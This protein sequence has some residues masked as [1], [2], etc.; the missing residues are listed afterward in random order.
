MI[1]EAFFTKLS[2]DSG[3]SAIAST[4]VYPVRLPQNPVFPCVSFQVI[5]E[6][7]IYTMEGASA[8]TAYI[9]VDCWAKTHLGA[10]QLAEAVSLCLS[11]FRGTMGSGGTARH[12]SA[13]LQQS[14]TDLFEPGVNDYR[15]S[16]DFSVWYN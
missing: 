14:M 9:Q 15:V 10:H 16:L 1:V 13:C 12:V 4:R 3:V 7:R 2:T 5:T 8:P 6:P 11:G